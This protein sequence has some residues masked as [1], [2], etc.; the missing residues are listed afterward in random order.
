ML[1]FRSNSLFFKTLLLYIG[2][3]I[4]NLTVFVTMIFEN[5]LDLISENAVLNSQMRGTNLKFRTD[6]ILKN[7]NEISKKNLEEILKEARFLGIRTFTIFEENGRIILDIENGKV[8]KRDQAEKQEIEWIN[9]AITR[10]SF[11]DKIFTHN[12]RRSDKSIELYIPVYYGIDKIVILRPQLM[13]KDIEQQMT[14]LYRQCAIIGLFLIIIHLVMGFILS[15]MVLKP[16]AVL[17]DATYK[18]AGGDLTA[19][20]DLVRSDEIGQLANSFNEMTVSLARMQEEARGANPLTGLPG[21]I[22]IVNELE[23]RLQG[24]RK[25]AVL[26]CDLDNFKAYNDK[27]G[28]NRGDD[29]ILYTKETLQAAVKK[30]GKGDNFIGHEGGDDFVMIAEVETWEDI[31][32]YFISEFDYGISK[33][34][35]ETD[36]KNRYI[37]SI[38]RQGIPMRFP[39]ISISVAVV[40][41]EHRHFKSYAGVVTVA[42]EMK[43]FTK[44]KQG[45]CYAIDR[46]S[47]PPPGG[48]KVKPVRKS[49]HSATKEPLPPG[50]QS[51]PV[52]EKPEENR[53]DT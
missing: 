40:S 19:R 47:D 5:Q 29:V 34:Y 12:I 2:I 45:S 35:N 15:R 53:R 17:N 31:A 3:T 33:F 41:N 39:L 48:Y 25:F 36:A 6:N 52:Y 51:T 11:E 27:Y 50:V 10:T 26:Y 20:V 16:L 49:E 8:K 32:K 22:A 44:S 9:K 21:N 1:K 43:K 4:L 13:M 7:K 30:K 38:N 23:R 42:G 46:R 18:I 14:Y 28:F 37:E 24:S